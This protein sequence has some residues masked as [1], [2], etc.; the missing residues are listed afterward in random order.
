M[1]NI[2]LNPI[3]IPETQL[4]VPTATVGTMMFGKRT[5]W[6]ES[7]RIVDIAFE[8]GL[9]FFDT[10]TMYQDGES[11]RFLGTALRGRRDKCIISTKVGYGKGPNGKEE[12][13]SY[14]AI[15]RAIDRSLKNLGTDYVDIYYLHRPDYATPIEETLQAICS[16]IEAGKICYYG[17]SNYASWQCMEILNLCAA[18]GWS[19][20][21]TSQVMYNPLFRQIEIEHV[22]FAKAY[23]IF[24]TVYNPL[25]GGLLTGEYLSVSKAKKA[26]R[27]HQNDLYCRRYLSERFL[28]GVLGLKRIAES[29]SLTLTHLTLNWI[30]RK[31]TVDN[32][33]LGPSTS[34]QL[35]DCLAA[36]T[37]SLR[38][39]LI[40]KIDKYLTRFEGTE[41]RYAR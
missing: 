20:P 27:F 38:K 7:A 18:N 19:K 12:G 25:A 16:L 31:G 11:E 41:A 37:I 35:L 33:I 30:V 3:P 8:H 29:E 17:L 2:L 15:I 34:E 36:G 39:E 10:A 26:S 6:K 22:P 40:R 23:G 24:L 9:N 32:L 13:L 1:L 28:Q 5:D 4:A 14:S 21:V